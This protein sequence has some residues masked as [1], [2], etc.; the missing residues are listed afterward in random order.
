M[1]A[2]ASQVAR[3]IRDQYMIGY[4]S[5]KSPTLGGYRA[6]RV[7]ARNRNNGKLIV[8]TRKGYYPGQVKQMHAVE[9]AQKAH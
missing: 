8:R 5:T 9:T 6:V 2:I 1:S 7:E 3:D 4:H